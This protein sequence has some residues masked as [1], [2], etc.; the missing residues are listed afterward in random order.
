MLL[1]RIAALVLPAF[2]FA[3]DAATDGHDEDL[4]QLTADTFTDSVA[5][6]AW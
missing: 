3:A 5:H 2:A 4:R 6:G 1:A